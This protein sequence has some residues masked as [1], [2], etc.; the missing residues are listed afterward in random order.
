M[1]V[2]GFAA[3]VSGERGVGEAAGG[4]EG[5]AADG[6]GGR[7]GYTQHGCKM[8]IGRGRQVR[9]DSWTTGSL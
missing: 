1:E 6:R 2:G 5:C 7:L 8:V 3:G 9:Y 4:G